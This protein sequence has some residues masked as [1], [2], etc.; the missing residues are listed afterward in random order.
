MTLTYKLDLDMVKMTFH[1]STS[2]SGVMQ[3]SRD[4]AD[5]HTHTRQADCSAWTTKRSVNITRQE[6]KAKAAEKSRSSSAG[7]V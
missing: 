6:V 3:S 2:R 5:T 7:A 4:H 1:A